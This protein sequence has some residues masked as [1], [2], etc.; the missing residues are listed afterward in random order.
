MRHLSR[1]L[2]LAFAVSQSRVG[3]TP[4]WAPF[5]SRGHLVAVQVDQ[6]V[7][8]SVDSRELDRLPMPQEPVFWLFPAK[9]QSALKSL[10]KIVTDRSSNTDQREKK[11]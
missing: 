11:R 7:Q 2:V 4:K 5:A 9:T 6:G 1:P 10:T 3:V 8:R